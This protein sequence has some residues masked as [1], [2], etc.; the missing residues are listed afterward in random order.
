MTPQKIDLCARAYL[1]CYRSSFKKYAWAHDYAE[2]L[3]EN[4]P[5]AALV[6]VVEVLNIA[7]NDEELAYVA[8]GLLEDLLSL[9]IQTLQSKVE[10]LIRLE[11]PLYMA[12]RYVWAK[13]NSPLYSFLAKLPVE[14][15]RQNLRDIPIE[16]NQK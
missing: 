8:S 4:N 1:E 9:H 12:M 10:N 14:I 15:R 6:F 2:N 11:P 16:R 13:E 3:I 7:I 5:K